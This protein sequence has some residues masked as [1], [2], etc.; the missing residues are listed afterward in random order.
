MDTPTPGAYILADTDAFFLSDLI[1][2]WTAS[3]IVA[4]EDY[5]GDIVR[6]LYRKCWFDTEF[7]L[8]GGVVNWA[9]EY[10]RMSVGDSVV[11]TISFS[12]NMTPED[13]ANAINAVFPDIASIVEDAGNY[14]L[15]FDSQEE[16]A[17][18]AY[19]AQIQTDL[20][21]FIPTSLNNRS[22]NYSDTGYQIEYTLSQT[23]LQ[24]R[25]AG[26]SA[27]EDLAT[28]PGPLPATLVPNVQ[29]EVV[30]PAA[31]HIGPTE[32]E[33]N[34]EAGFYYAEFD[35][36]S[37]GIGD[38]FNIPADLYGQATGYKCSGYHLR[39]DSEA[40]S[41]SPSEELR[42]V[43]SNSFLEP[44]VEARASQSTIVA[45]SNI[46]IDY[47]YSELVSTVN[48]FVTS[49]SERV[50][51]SS[52]LCKHMLPY[53]VGA[54]INYRGGPTETVAKSAIEEVIET[55]FSGQTL[56]IHDVV[57]ALSSRGAS[58]VEMP[59]VL[60]VLYQDINRSM[61]VE[62]VENTDTLSRLACF[63]ADLDRLSLNRLG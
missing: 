53:Y 47:D 14:W 59:V 43:I 29:Y 33:D 5:P 60:Y 49:D 56:E 23:Q 52:M 22:A 17:N 28:G 30:R 37:Y 41:L 40:L 20:N 63:F 6:V 8:V 25:F 15:T 42:L 7:T 46:R 11:R 55:V 18:V 24:L 32:M 34:T 16:I 61:W 9:G 10:L 12:N 58:Y 19:S 13:V 2:D 44:G 48:S 54:T 39:A 3:R 31:Y 35:M 4:G 36:I 51:V 27:E 57:A 50:K 45:S 26:F 1:Q 38:E 62:L 21:D